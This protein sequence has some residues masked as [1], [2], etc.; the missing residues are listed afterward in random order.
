M[1]IK[2]VN[3]TN[4][5]VRAEC[6]LHHVNLQPNTYQNCDWAWADPVLGG[7]ASVSVWFGG[8]AGTSQPV[9]EGYTVTWDGNKATVT[10]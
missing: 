1:P 8:L 10:I 6:T 4:G 3:A 7:N 9:V 5:V 2:V